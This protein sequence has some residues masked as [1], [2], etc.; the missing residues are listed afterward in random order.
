MIP[1]GYGVGQI[2]ARAV[3]RSSSPVEQFRAAASISSKGVP[4]SVRLRPILIRSNS[5]PAPG[6]HQ[7]LCQQRAM[8]KQHETHLVQQ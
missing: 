7:H 6:H 4:N 5:H 1:I 3:S 8:P 2:Q